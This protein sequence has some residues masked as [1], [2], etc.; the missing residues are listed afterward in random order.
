VKFSL[1]YPVIY[2][3]ETLEKTTNQKW[4]YKCTY[5][6]NISVGIISCDMAIADVYDSLI[7]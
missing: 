3:Y 4:K 7:Y 2:S 5:K 6:Y 1:Q